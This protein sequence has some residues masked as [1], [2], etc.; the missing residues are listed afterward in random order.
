MVTSSSW[1][2]SL[3]R[4]TIKDAN[5]KLTTVES[6]FA[7]NRGSGGSGSGSG[8]F[9]SCFAQ[10]LDFSEFGGNNSNNNNGKNN[11]NSSNKSAAEELLI[12]KGIERKQR[13]IQEQEEIKMEEALQIKSET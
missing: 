12:V 6:I 11:S 10:G 5:S 1:P 9:E 8:G 2:S 7:G 4:A 3:Q 13:Q